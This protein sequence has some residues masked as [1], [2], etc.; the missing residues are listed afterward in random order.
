[1]TTQNLRYQFG[2]NLRKNRENNVVLL[3]FQH[4]APKLFS[5]VD[6][7]RMAKNYAIPVFHECHDFTPHEF[8]PL[9][10]GSR[11]LH[12]YCVVKIANRCYHISNSELSYFD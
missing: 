10:E 6:Y 5:K 3:K 12:L 1:M 2:K 4:N 9:P 8:Q 11:G 7:T